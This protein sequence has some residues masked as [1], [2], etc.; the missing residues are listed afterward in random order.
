MVKHSVAPPQTF[1]SGRGKAPLE[2]PNPPVSY[3][4]KDGG[5]CG[6]HCVSF[7]SV[8]RGRVDNNMTVK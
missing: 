1:Q 7:I 4:Y 2:S 8:N 6:M 5:I 3:T